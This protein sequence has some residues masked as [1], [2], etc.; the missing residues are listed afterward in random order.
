LFGD[1]DGDRDVDGQDY[2]RF[3]RSFLKSQGAIDF[4]A[5]MDR[6][7][8]GNVDVDGQD[9]GAFLRNFHRSLPF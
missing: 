8:D 4:N 2:G 3:G 9:Y 7:G 6:E 5:A 1:D